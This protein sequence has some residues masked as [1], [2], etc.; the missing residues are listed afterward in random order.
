MVEPFFKSQKKKKVLTRRGWRGLLN[1]E[2]EVIVK[3]KRAF[4]GQ[5]GQTIKRY[6]TGGH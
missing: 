6:E 2:E 4:N 5:K 3:A 1:I